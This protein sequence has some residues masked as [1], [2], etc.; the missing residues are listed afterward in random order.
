M[1]A[2]E[3]EAFLEGYSDYLDGLL[4]AATEE[5]FERHIRECEHCARY[6]RVVQR[7]LALCH[8]LPDID[9]SPD[10]LPRL[11]HRI[12]HLEDGIP[13]SSVRP[14]G[15]AALVAVA[16]VGLLAFAWLPFAT[17]V[18]VEVELPA[19]AARAPRGGE[20]TP[21]EHASAGGLSFLN[22]RFHLL[23]TSSASLF[24]GHGPFLSTAPLR[25]SHGLDALDGD[26]FASAGAGLSGGPS[27]LAAME[28]RAAFAR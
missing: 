7:G 4:G 5:E 14:G 11:R 2:M 8:E 20:A 21:A 12:Y 16:A 26:F 27:F 17:S 3:C 28:Q 24:S 1:T 15:S 23:G 13:M 6:D 9:G 22:G 10:F 25:L 18:P 19:V